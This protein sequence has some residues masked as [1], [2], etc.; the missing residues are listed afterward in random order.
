[1]N[2]VVQYFVSGDS[3]YGGALLLVLAVAAS[4][5]LKQRWWARLRN[6]AAW[7]GL[8]LV[9]MAC[10]PF[11]WTADAIFLVS[12]ALWLAGANQWLGWTETQWRPWLA[13]V[14]L[15]VLLTLTAIEL[16]HRRIPKIVGI[17]SDHLVVI[18]DSISSGIDPRVPA[19]PMVMQQL[20]NVTVRNL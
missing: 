5:Y 4:R 10:P 1:M 15:V 7:L 2:P 8:A 19:W 20:T 6:L 16:P 13:V 3:F 17:P 14:L 12:F 9:V 11:P 18:G